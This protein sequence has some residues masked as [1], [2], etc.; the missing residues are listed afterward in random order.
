MSGNDSSELM[1]KVDGS[2]ITK[3][4]DKE[5]LVSVV[6]PVYNPSAH[7]GEALKSVLAQDLG[8]E[9]MQIAVVDDASQ[10]V[11]VAALLNKMAPPGRVELYRNQ[12]NLGLAGN[13]NECARLARGRVVHILHQDDWIADGFYRRMLPAFERYQEVGMAFCRHAYA[14][15]EGRIVYRT[16]RE[17]WFP[18]RL[19]GWLEKIAIKQ[20]IQCASVLVRRSVYE[21]LGAYRPDLVYALDW[22][23]W[24]R[25]AAHYSVWFEPTLMAFYR[26]HA[27]NETSRLA[28]QGR[29]AADEENAIRIFSQ[30]LP[31]S[32]RDRLTAMAL[33]RL[34]R[35]AEK[36]RS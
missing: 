3:G 9:S 14:D 32:N 10:E 4:A 5:P 6:I 33:D 8:P 29:V 30:Y 24:V 16:H 18:G 23:M 28:A 27:Q 22:E 31:V 35:K 36:H 7:L 26:R 12:R 15:S 2:S 13:W 21:H 17:R 11:D 25:V 1:V 19:A 34:Q 20:R